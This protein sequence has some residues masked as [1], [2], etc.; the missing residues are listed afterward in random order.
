MFYLRRSLSHPQIA[1]GIQWTLYL[2]DRSSSHKES[3]ATMQVLER[4]IS[5]N[6][7]MLSAHRKAH[8][9]DILAHSSRNRQEYKRI[10][11]DHNIMAQVKIW[12]LSM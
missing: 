11:S 12:L 10:A 1:L 9:V 8:S 3:F 4:S 2:D 6:K 5:I 7:Q